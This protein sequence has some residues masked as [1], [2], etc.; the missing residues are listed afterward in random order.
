MCLDNVFV[1]VTGKLWEFQGQFCNWS[2][3]RTLDIGIFGPYAQIFHE[4]LGHLSE[5]PD[6][7]T[8]DIDIS[9]PYVWI[10]DV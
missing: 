2:D 6:I 8:L 1:C 5:L 3:V 9:G 7:R 10:A 4:A